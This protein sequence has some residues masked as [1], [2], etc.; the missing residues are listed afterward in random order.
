MLL[1]QCWLIYLHFGLSLVIAECILKIPIFN[2][3]AVSEF[4][5]SLS[6]GWSWMCVCWFAVHRTRTCYDVKAGVITLS[7]SI[8]FFL[9]SLSLGLLCQAAWSLYELTLSFSYTTIKFLMLLFYPPTHGGGCTAQLQEKSSSFV[10]WKND[11]KK[12]KS[13]FFYPFN[14][15]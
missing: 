9:F 6:S 5:L 14:L 7:I 1:F 4:S 2:I 11:K 15:G 10:R 12:S 3:F 13:F 8:N